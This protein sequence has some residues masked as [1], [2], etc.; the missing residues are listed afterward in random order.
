MSK[1]FRLRGIRDKLVASFSL[2]V[3]TGAIFFATFFPARFEEQAMRTLVARGEA[4]SDMTSYSLESSLLFNDTASVREII[5]DVARRQRLEFAMVQDAAGGSVAARGL[6]A[7]MKASL[8]RQSEGINADGSVYIA[9]VPVTRNGS[10]LGSLTVGLSLM[11]LRAEV[12]LARNVARIAGLMTLVVGLLIVFAISSLVT[13]PLT[14]ISETVARIAAG[15]LSLRAEEPSDVEV[16]NLV[17]GFNGMVANLAA[18]Q[19]ELSEYNHRLE[20]L[21]DRRT[22]K[23]RRAIR[24]ERRASKALFASEANARATTETMRSLIDLAPQP[25]LAVDLEWRITW[26]N[27]AAEELF[28]WAS[29]EVLGRPLPSIPDDQRA[30]FIVWQG[31]LANGNAPRASEV[32]HCR[33]DGSRVPVLLS[34]GVLRGTDKQPSG[35]LAFAT[36]LRERKSLENQLLHSQKME[37]VGRLAGGVAHDFN[38]ILTVIL[39][40][41]S[42]LEG[43]NLSDEDRV[44]ATEISAAANRAAR[45]TRQLLTF[46]RQQIDQPRL[47]TIDDI[48]R[49]MEPMLR[50]V[51]V[52]SVNLALELEHTSTV[53][54]DPGQL[55]Q[56]LMNLVVNAADAM[57]G[58]GSLVIAAKDVTI[59]PGMSA[60]VQPGQYAMM[61]VRDSGIGMEAATLEKIF[62]PFFT[63]KELGMGTGLGLATSYAITSRIG[64]HIRVSSQPG[65]GS[66]FRVYLPHTAGEGYGRNNAVVANDEHPGDPM[67]VLLVEDD[68]AVRKVIKRGLEGLGH[69]VIEAHDGQSGL[70]MA[71]AHDGS[72]DLVLTD[73][74]MPGMNG[75]EFVRQL[76]KS[77]RRVPVV[78]M[79]GYAQDAASRDGM[80]GGDRAFLQKPFSAATIASTL[81]QMRRGDRPAIAAA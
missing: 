16:A 41:A 31:Q 68:A 67:T 1:F 76:E 17:R 50:R 46:S 52:T 70:E 69:R 28:G 56:V 39:G 36:D 24:K 79:S 35:Y 61:T 30:Q 10:R 63:T 77:Y 13:R 3:A 6:S 49:K 18:A 4:I 26:W 66:S 2:L 75:R 22:I 57:P 23:L 42:V 12:A 8:S 60:E 51:V 21:V 53:M 7:S 72:I 65:H 48:I 25:I 62:E 14:A 40:C 34:L 59:L 9:I 19:A 80:E 73:I 47:V 74:T 37:A 15:D 27:R 81:R 64:G 20:A 78:F 58:G 44:E 71:A 32:D 33:K 43:A 11:D 54:A 45:L 29:D 5:T 55:E 38:N